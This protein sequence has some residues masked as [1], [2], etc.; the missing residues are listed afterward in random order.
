MINTAT[1]RPAFPWMQ[2]NRLLAFLGVGHVTYLSG[3]FLHNGCTHHI[4]LDWKSL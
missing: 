3:R 2:D 1:A 4:F